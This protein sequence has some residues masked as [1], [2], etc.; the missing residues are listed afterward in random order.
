MN[1]EEFIKEKLGQVL[2]EISNQQ[3]DMF[4]KYYEM[5]IDKN[6]YMNLTSITDFE[7]F[8]VK[9]FLDSLQILRVMNYNDLSSHDYSL[10]DIGTGAGFPGIPLKIAFPGLKVT[11]FDSLNKRLVFLDEVISTLGLKDI[12]TVHGRAEEFGRKEEFREKYDIVVSRAVAGLNSL[13]EFCLPF[14]RVNGFF[15]SY[16]GSKGD[17]EL[18]QAKNAVKLLGGCTKKKV[19]FNLCGEDNDR[20]VIMIEKVSPCNSKYPRAGGKPLKSPL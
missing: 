10:I 14:C 11:L 5:I 1:R 3:T 18:L 7:E 19:S 2:P 20:T 15:I 12:C 16:K 9:H 8:V 17:D 4:I 6:N 13:C